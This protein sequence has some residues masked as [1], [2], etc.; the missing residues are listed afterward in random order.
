MIKHRYISAMSLCVCFV[1]FVFLTGCSDNLF[2]GLDG[3]TSAETAQEASDNGDYVAAL[4]LSQAVINDP[5]ATTQE[6]QIA[7][8][9]KGTALLG[10]NNISILSIS[11]KL[12]DLSNTPVSEQ[13]F[14][15]TLSTLFPLTPSASAEIADT[16]NMAYTLGGGS[17]SAISLSSS[18][19]SLDTNKQLLRGMANLSVVVRMTSHAFNIAS[20]GSVSLAENFT[21]YSDALD[22][23]MAGSHTVVYYADH[24]IDGFTAAEAFTSEQLEQARK[25]RIIGLNISNLQA[26]NNVPGTM[27]TLQTYENEGVS[28]TPVTGPNAYSAVVNTEAEL[29]AALNSIF[30]YIKN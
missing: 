12:R 23:L 30:R 22:Y 15:S 25:V 1:A 14:I 13:N 21:S 19:S 7:Y 18:G 11:S 26:V 10:L 8:A 24:A 17:L 9:Q 5:G 16:F 4:A 6:K 20:D 27:F 2:K 3:D 28:T 29:Q